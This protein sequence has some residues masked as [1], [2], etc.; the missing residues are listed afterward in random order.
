MNWIPSSDLSQLVVHYS[1]TCQIPFLFL[2]HR[3]GHIHNSC[4]FGR[5]LTLQSPQLFQKQKSLL[6]PLIDFPIVSPLSLSSPVSH[7]HF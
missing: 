6:P 4:N 3:P 1:T 2:A 7:I 5:S